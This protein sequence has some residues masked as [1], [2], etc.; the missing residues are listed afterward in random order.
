MK[1]RAAE[2]NGLAYHISALCVVGL[3]QFRLIAAGEIDS[4]RHELITISRLR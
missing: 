3:H 2:Q 1:D 4:L